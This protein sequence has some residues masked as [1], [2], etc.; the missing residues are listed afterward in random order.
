MPKQ[1]KKCNTE[2]IEVT[3]LEPKRFSGFTRDWFSTIYDFCYF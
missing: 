1:C 2:N 3:F